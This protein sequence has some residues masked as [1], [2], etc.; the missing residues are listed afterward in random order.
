MVFSG[1][2]YLEVTTFKK[3]PLKVLWEASVQHFSA[4][5]L[6]RLSPE[7]DVSLEFLPISNAAEA[8]N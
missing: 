4:R 6:S 1:L 8:L 7:A 3:L 2:L 5:S